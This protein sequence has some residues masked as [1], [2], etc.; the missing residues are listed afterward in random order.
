MPPNTTSLKEKIKSAI[1]GGLFDSDSVIDALFDIVS[2][3]QLIQNLKFGL[4]SGPSKSSE[5]PIPTS[6][7]SLEDKIKALV[8][9]VYFVYNKD[10][11]FIP[12]EC[13]IG[14]WHQ[15]GFIG[16]DKVFTFFTK[17]WCAFD[18][19]ELNNLMKSNGYLYFYCDPCTDGEWDR[20]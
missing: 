12:A 11:N 6:T 2:E 4:L 1:S 3:E 9:D 18:P 10:D 5:K 7:N 8:P 16:R 17:D 14:K 20:G 13:K 15:Y 19:S